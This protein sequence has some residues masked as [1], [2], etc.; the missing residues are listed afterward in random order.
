[1]QA[2]SGLGG[3][4]KTQIAV[5]YVYRYR[6]DYSAIFWVQAATETTRLS[7]LQIIS[8][9][10]QL[11]SSQNQ[12]PETTIA[13]F[14][15]WLT[16]N[17]NW[18][19]VFDDAD[20]PEQLRSL[21]PQWGQGHILITARIPRF[22]SLGLARP[23]CLDPLSQ[24]ESVTFLMQRT[25]RL[26]DNAEELSAAQGI[27]TEVGGL[28][29]ALEQ[30][31]AYILERQICFQDYLVSF[32][33]QRLAILQ[34][35]RP[36]M[37]DYPESISTTWSLNFQAVASASPL[38][39]DILCVSA[40]LAPEAIPYEL[41]ERGGVLILGKTPLAVALLQAKHDPTTMADLL[42]P[43][44][45]YS[46]VSIDPSAR[47]Y[48]LHRLVQQAVRLDLLDQ[49]T[50]RQWQIIAIDLIGAIFPNVDCE[51][52]EECNRFIAQGLKGQEW[53]SAL[54]YQS[55]QA[56][57][58]L[59]RVS[60]YLLWQG[61]YEA[62]EAALQV[63]LTQRQHLF[64]AP[65][66]AIGEVLSQF[67]AL[68]RA[69]GRYQEA[70]SLYQQALVHYQQALEYDTLDLST[71]LNRLGLLYRDKGDFSKAISLHQ[72]ALDIRQRLTA[73]DDFYIAESLNDLAL[74]YWKQSNYELAESLFLQS[75]E[76]Y[77]RLEG[78]ASLPVAVAS[79]NLALIYRAQKR[80]DSAEILYHKT[81]KLFKQILGEQHPDIAMV[82]HNLGSLFEAR[83]AYDEAQNYYERAIVLRRE[84]LG[85]EHP[86]LATSVHRLAS[87]HLLKGNNAQAQAL[88]RE[89]LNIRIKELGTQH[90]ATR[91]TQQALT[92]LLKIHST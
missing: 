8:Q 49:T 35:S 23:V 78:D 74:S 39:A 77:R 83:G 43:L 26:P 24:E 64:E 81:L 41:F 25:G 85:G 30:A 61:H 79:N 52:W 15:T 20:H 54:G 76:M 31:A 37:G 40:F 53:I 69:Q 90:P 36:V 82:L 11:P 44:A 51:A 84:L 86:Y 63:A 71:T 56:A 27:A 5:E 73:K 42:A 3:I 45:R 1:M 62:A 21:L 12:S 67:G 92:K 4:G 34:R 55:P 22:D 19:L 89:A 9:V 2:L 28:P 47:T 57:Q 70:E 33:Q 88:Y 46:L 66:S 91:K 17:S 18:L 50:E 80:Y 75:L 58:L 38:A 60:Q 7:S 32:R 13:A 87:I 10:L 68:R 65:H 29:L 72:Q 16:Q 59:H 14:C 48:S 6:A